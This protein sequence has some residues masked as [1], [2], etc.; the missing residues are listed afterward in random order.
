MTIV[1]VWIAGLWGLDVPASVAQAFTILAATG[2]SI[3][4]PDD[5]EAP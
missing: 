4:V 5:M 3:L 2:L 1:V